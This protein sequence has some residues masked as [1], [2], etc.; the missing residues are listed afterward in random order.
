MTES[1]C[2]T[3]TSSSNRS[4][5]PNH[6]NF[7]T[8]IHHNIESPHTSRQTSPLFTPDTSS[9]P[10]VYTKHELCVKSDELKS[11]SSELTLLSILEIIRN[12]QRKEEG[13][14]KNKKRE[15]G[16]KRSSTS[17][18]T[19]D[20]IDTDCLTTIEAHRSKRHA[21]KERLNLA[22][23]KIRGLKDEREEILSKFDCEKPWRWHRDVNYITCRE[24][25]RYE[26]VWIVNCI[27]KA[28]FESFKWGKNCE[29]QNGKRDEEDVMLSSTVKEI[30][31]RSELPQSILGEIYSL[32][33]STH[34]WMLQKRE[35]IVGMWLVDQSL[36]GRRLP[37]AVDENIWLCVDIGG[38]R[39][40][41]RDERSLYR[42][43]KRLLKEEMKSVKRVGKHS[44]R[45]GDIVMV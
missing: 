41:P 25:S 44:A 6:H 23:L 36:Y 26:G 16:Q 27:S 31:D 7:T 12:I 20:L 1:S 30:W 24:Y 45:G 19:T 21:F 38:Q 9:E 4:T 32:V 33:D 13:K 29:F 14:Y 8:T 35:F 40:L 5:R 3:S 43:K 42:E 22:T 15:R 37:S 28:R 2:S 11:L 18:S 17:T 39:L 34:D 10:T